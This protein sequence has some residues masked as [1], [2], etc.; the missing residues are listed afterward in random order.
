MSE[1]TRKTNYQW[2]TVDGDNS[3]GAAQL[4][5]LQDLRDELQK[6]NTL[7]HCPNAIRIPQILD[8]IRRNTT[9]RKRK[10]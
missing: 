10:K 9:K 2:S 1:Y 7:L 8:A 6:L 3:F 4:Q 5:V